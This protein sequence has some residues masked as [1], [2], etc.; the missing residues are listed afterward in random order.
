MEV[1]ILCIINNT[2]YFT[3]KVENCYSYIIYFFQYEE[4]IERL[5]STGIR[6]KT[7]TVELCRLMVRVTDLNT[8]T[9]LA[10]LIRT[11]DNPCR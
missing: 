7:H 1:R 8:K 10:S 11:A 6:T 2:T 9:T 3:S 4:E 5:K